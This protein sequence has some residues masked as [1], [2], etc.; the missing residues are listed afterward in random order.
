MSS[1]AQSIFIYGK[2]VPMQTSAIATRV[3]AFS[4][5][6]TLGC[7]LN[8]QKKIILKTYVFY[9]NEFNVYLQNIC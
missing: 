9:V 3:N 8:N 6:K 7:F 5:E 4:K 1:Y 2:N